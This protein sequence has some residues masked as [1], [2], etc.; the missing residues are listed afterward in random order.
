[1]PDKRRKIL[2]IKPSSLGDIVHSLP[3]LDTLCRCFPG[4]ALHWLVAKGFEALLEDHP[5]LSK[6]WI[7]HK[8][9]WKRIS[10]LQTTVA[11][12]R[13]LF[14]DLRKERF[15]L[16]IDLQGLFRSGLIA[17]ATGA[18]MRIG[19]KEAREGSTTFYTHAVEGGKDIHAVDRYLKI[20]AFLGC[21]V[22]PVRF[23]FP[24]PLQSPSPGLP[25]P[26]EYAVM[27]PGARKPVNRWPAQ[28]FGELAARLPVRTLVLGSRGDR[29]LA[30]EV[31]RASRGNAESL[32]G[33]T[34]IR[35][36]VQV[37]RGARFMVS[38]DTGPM[39]I[40]AAIGIPVF[41]LFGPA[42]PVRTG[43]YGKGHRVIRRE[44][45]CAP[46]YRRSCKDPRCLD[47]ITVEEVAEII[48]NSLRQNNAT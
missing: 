36:L 17:K 39:H 16:V 40:A 44:I 12:L 11:E 14:R 46:C 41:A 3:V 48:R 22:A 28:R 2:I 9:E 30:E 10:R 33:K 15:D 19:F 1:M 34:D 26:G 31:V 6:V 25:V 45:S 32:A 21:K 27:V 23:P 42:N 43:P 8:D 29:M 47:M 24:P 4:A 20:P 35:G 37:I 5:M 18:P 13:A 38:N 7:I